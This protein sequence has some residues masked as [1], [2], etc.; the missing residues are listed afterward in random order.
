MF[1]KIPY[2]FLNN[3]SD[4]TPSEALEWIK[5][6]QNPF[7]DNLFPFWGQLDYQDYEGSCLFLLVN[8]ITKEFFEI[9]GSHCSCYGFED[10]FEPSLAPVEY[11]FKQQRRWPDAIK[12][13][14]EILQNNLETN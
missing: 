6:H 8:P 10:Q 5:S 11:I 1:F 14:E 7:P 13:V 2:C 4:W 9:S 3:A 12:L